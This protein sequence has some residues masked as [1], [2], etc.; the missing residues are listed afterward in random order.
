MNGITQAIVGITED[1]VTSENHHPGYVLIPTER[2]DRLK[3]AEAIIVA[4]PAAPQKDAPLGHDERVDYEMRILA[5]EMENEHLRRTLKP[6]ATKAILWNGEDRK[7]ARDSQQV[8]HRLG[9]FRAA[10]DLIY[11]ERL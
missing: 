8:Q 6:F 1:Y 7:Y 5:V 3:R 10:H 9:D 2:F 4:H 11:G